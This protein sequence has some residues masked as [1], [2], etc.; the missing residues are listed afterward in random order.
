MQTREGRRLD[1][2]VY[3]LRCADGSL[4]TGITNRLLPRL[5]AHARGRGAKYTR[6]RGPFSLLY[7]E[8][9]PTKGIALRREAVIKSLSRA[10]KLG[11]V[12]A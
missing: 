8:W 11:L 9:H 7:T 6:G 10:A 12:I 3:I 5:Q 2:A 1:W 4:Y